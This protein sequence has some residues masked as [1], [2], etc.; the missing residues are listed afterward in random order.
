MI[1]KPFTP[2][3]QASPW[4]GANPQPGPVVFASLLTGPLGQRSVDDLGNTYALVTPGENPKL[5]VEPGGEWQQRLVFRRELPE[6]AQSLTLITNFGPE[7][8]KPQQPKFTLPGIPI[9]LSRQR[10]GDPGFYQ[11]AGE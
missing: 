5:Q 4:D 2:S 1:A 7:P 9:V 3:S 8:E 11:R 10:E 6:E